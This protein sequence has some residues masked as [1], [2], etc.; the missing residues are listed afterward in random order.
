MLYLGLTACVA[1]SLT[2]D[3]VAYISLFLFELRA[4]AIREYTPNLLWEV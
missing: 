4:K 2:L 1:F 3:C